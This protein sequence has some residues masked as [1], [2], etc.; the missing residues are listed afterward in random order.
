MSNLWLDGFAAYA[1]NTQAIRIPEL[2][3]CNIGS[4]GGVTGRRGGKALYLSA[5]TKYYCI[6][7]QNTPADNTMIFLGFAVKPS[8][9]SNFYYNT[10]YPW[11]QISDGAGN[12]HFYV[13]LKHGTRI[14]EV[15]DSAWTVLGTGTIPI[16]NVWMY[17]ELKATIHDTTGIIQ[18]RINK[19]V[20]IDLTGQDTKNGSNGYVGFIKIRAFC[21]VTPCYMDDLYLN[22]DQGSENNDY[23]GDIRIDEL[24][25]NGAGAHTDFTPS[26]GANYQNVDEDAPDD[27]TTYNYG[28]TIGN[29][30]TYALQSLEV[31][32]SDIL[33]VKNQITLRK[34]DAGTRKAKIISRLNGTDYLGDELTLSDSYLTFVK[35]YELNPDDSAAFEEADIAGMESGVEITA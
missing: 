21:D 33:A 31:L 17:F 14:Y 28:N 24:R 2:L 23:S 30:D 1:T 35:I 18:T 12:N 34:D 8:N 6:D 4:A 11:I 7:L 20:D 29:Q 25:P 15:R 3:N 27:D 26:A 16:S 32:G 13:T 19:T 5:Y 10:S 22:N 9:L